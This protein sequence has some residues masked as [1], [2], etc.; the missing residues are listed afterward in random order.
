MRQAVSA[1]VKYGM[2][3]RH[4]HLND[5]NIE[6]FSYKIDCLNIMRMGHAAVSLADNCSNKMWDLFTDQD[7]F[8]LRNIDMATSWNH[9]CVHV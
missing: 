9:A 5:I 3:G 6:T 8:L 4:N 7:G 2:M 1:H